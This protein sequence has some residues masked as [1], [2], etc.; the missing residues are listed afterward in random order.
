VTFPRGC[1]F[2]AGRGP[3]EV[4]WSWHAS[5]RFSAAV[6]LHPARTLS[7]LMVFRPPTSLMHLRTLFATLAPM[8]LVLSLSAQTPAAPKLEF[9]QASPSTVIKQRVGITDIEVNF[10]RPSKKGR[11]IFGGLVPYDQRWRTGANNATK[12]TFST[13]VKIN[14]AAI[15]AGT[16]ELFTIPGKAEWTIIIHKNMSQWGDYQYDEKNDVVRFKAKPVALP[17]TMETFAIGFS[18]LRDSSATFYLAWENVRVPMK[19]EVDVVGMLVPQIEAAMAAEGG[20]KPYV[21]AAM[22]YFENNLDLKKAIA[23][24][25]AGLAENPKAF[26]FIYRKGLILQKMGDK[27]GALAAAQQS[28]ALASQAQGAIKD[29]Y[30]RLNQAL[31]DS[32]K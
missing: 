8:A 10:A 19:L 21:P 5:G 13:A 28:M 29:E 12:L 4:L 22:F 31:I 18:D 15:P 17:T 3:D 7:I 2:S 23:W 14:G 9:P 30:V 16:Y 20:K 25:D 1:L 11:V 32:L 6:L 27:A 26:W 24:M